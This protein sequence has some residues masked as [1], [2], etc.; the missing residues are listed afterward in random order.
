MLI[1]YIFQKHKSLTRGSWLLYITLASL[2]DKLLSK[3]WQ[4]DLC[5]N[6]WRGEL[7]MC[8]TKDSLKRSGPKLRS[9]SQFAYK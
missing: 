8:L 2:G 3:C 4:V 1:I 7:E 9:F 5:V 6:S